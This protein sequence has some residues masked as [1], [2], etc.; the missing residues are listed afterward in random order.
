MTKEQ[1]PFEYME[2]VALCAVCCASV[3]RDI[4]EGKQK[5]RNEIKIFIEDEIRRI[6]SIRWNDPEKKVIE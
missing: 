6:V 4:T 3:V 1:K 2:L 5:G